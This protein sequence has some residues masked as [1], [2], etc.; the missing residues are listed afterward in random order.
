MKAY[1]MYKITSNEN[2]TND[3]RV[4]HL[5]KKKIL[6]MIMFLTLLLPNVVFAKEKKEQNRYEIPDHVLT[7]DKENTYPNETEDETIIEPSEF[8]KQ[9]LESSDVRVKNPD[10]IQMLNETNIR[11]TPFSFG[12]RG[13]IYLGR[14]AL[15]YE[16]TETT[17]NWEYQKINE[18]EL[19]NLG[20]D[21]PQTIYYEQ[22]SE[23][24]IQ[25]ALTSKISNA[26]DVKTM[27]LSKAKEKTNLPLAF[28]TYVG[29][30]TKKDNPYKIPPKQHG[31]LTVYAPAVN[32]KGQITF[33][34]VYIELKGTKKQLKIKN[35]TKQ[36]IGAWIPIQDHA[37]FSFR[38]K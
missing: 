32:E 1:F 27:M 36:G 19:N 23:N 29:K 25:G 3:E 31:V 38:L 5:K 28:T 21:S 6:I 17:I 18:N 14:W 16:S 26:E 8:T 15:N 13:D 35:V 33:G 10:L 34:E 2:N 11:P 4:I 24:K 37:S 12:Y 22:Q 9:L 30:G 7:I 20:G